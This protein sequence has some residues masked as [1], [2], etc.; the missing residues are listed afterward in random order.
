[1]ILEKL[2]EYQRKIVD[3]TV[4]RSGAAI[5]A[6]QGTGKTWITA[7]VVEELMR[8][9]YQ[10]GEDFDALLVVP[11][12][13]IETTWVR[14]FETIPQLTVLRSWDD[15]KRFRKNATPNSNPA[16]VLL[17]HYE[18][19]R[20]KSLVRKIVKRRWSLVV[21]DES[22]RLKSRSS[23][24]S[25]VA[26]RF[27]DVGYRMI[28]SGTPIEQCPQDLWAQ[29]RFA[30]PEVFGTRWSD[31]ESRWLRPTGFM[32]YEL[33]FRENLM[34][35]F[36]KL[37]HP[38]IRRVLKMDVLDLP[39]LTYKRATVEMMGDQARAYR[40]VTRQMFAEVR[41][42]TVTCDMAITQLIRQQQITGGFT[43][44]DHT[45]EELRKALEEMERTGRR[46]M[47]LKRRVVYFGS[48][49]LRRLKRILRRVTLPVVVFCKYKE[50]VLAISR[51]CDQLRVGII[52]GKRKDRKNRT[53][54]I[55]AFQR[56]DLDV[57][58]CQIRAG[59]V[60]IDLFRASEAIFYSCT[61]SSIDFEQAV[62]RLHRRGQTKPV[63][64]WLIQAANTVDTLIWQALLLKRSVT[65]LILNRR[66]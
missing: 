41:G 31:F 64:I 35:K 50:E 11:L 32:G 65:R 53:A 16:S 61:F 8:M 14:L 12:A 62:C 66:K 37:I 46:K 4:L 54:T 22:Q 26:A 9:S 5:F 29:F 45:E 10:D 49:K 60:G 44:L 57:L 1:M 21:Y 59:G 58:V 30:M 13:N 36:L 56:G 27:S 2:D 38:H 33:K 52:Q 43:H 7:G 17:L 39:P 19:L 24:A 47:R 40:D 63:R 34:P 3:W 25:R 48:A 6:E 42:G 18:A 15:H 55:D 23:D 51:A 28:L 20:G